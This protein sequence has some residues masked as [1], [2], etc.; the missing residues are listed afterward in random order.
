M[1]FVSRVACAPATSALRQGTGVGLVVIPVPVSGMAPR[2]HSNAPFHPS[3]TIPCVVA[4]VC[5]KASRWCVSVTVPPRQATGKGLPVMNVSMAT[6]GQSVPEHAQEVPVSP[7]STTVCVTW[8]GMPLDCALVSTT[9]PATG[10]PHPVP[11]VCWDTGAISASMIVSMPTVR[12]VLVTANV[13]AESEEMEPV[14][15]SPTQLMDGGWGNYVKHVS[16]GTLDQPAIVNVLVWHCRASSA[17]EEAPVSMG[18]QG[19]AR[20]HARLT[21]VVRAAR[22][23]VR[24]IPPAMY[25]PVEERVYS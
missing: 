20:A 4:M 5:A 13:M 22:F 18:F 12:S 3:S 10:T 7:A 2:A 8:A 6:S 15:A 21:I 25:A 19:T 17:Q 14:N 16:L 23:L 24:R 9:P 1:A 11:T